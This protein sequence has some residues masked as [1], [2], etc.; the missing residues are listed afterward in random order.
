MSDTSI[1]AASTANKEKPARNY[2][3]DLL[4][5]FFA[6]FIVLWHIRIKTNLVDTW[7]LIRGGGKVAVHFFFVVSGMLMAN[8]IMKKNADVDRPGKSAIQFTIGKFKAVAWPYFMSLIIEIPIYQFIYAKKPNLYLHF[9]QMF[10]DFFLIEAAGTYAAPALPSWYISAMLI[11]GLPISYMLFKKPDLMLNVLAPLLAVLTMGFM[12]QTDGFNLVEH[13]TLFGP[14][15]GGIIRAVSGLCF[16]LCA[17]TIY[18]KIKNA[19]LNKASRIALTIAE[20]LLYFQFFMTLFYV[21]NMKASV[22][23]LVMLPIPLAITFSGKSY[24]GCLFRFKWMKIFGPLSLYIY[25]NHWAAIL[26]ITKFYKARGLKFL[27]VVTFGLTLLFSLIC[28][29]LVKLGKLILKKIKPVFAKKD[30]Q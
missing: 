17:Y 13:T 10:P 9:S 11:V 23:A 7:P 24:A 22:S 28:F 19:D 8:S 5:L 2:E 3:L 14:V 29:I 18:T 15:M 25:L 1:T 21:D 6:V 12:N 4:K 30:T 26:I 27:L 16:G 20:V